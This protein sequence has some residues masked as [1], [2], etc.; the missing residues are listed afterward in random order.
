MKDALGHGSNAR[1]SHASKID[2]IGK[3]FRTA[4][5]AEFLAARNMSKR[6]EYF[7]PHTP[8]EIANFKLIMNHEGTVGAAVA[9]DGDIQSVFNNSG[10]KGAG[11][12]AIEIAK[13][14]GGQKLDAFDGALPDIY[15][16]HGFV[17]DHRE[18]N[19]NPGGPDVVYMRLKKPAS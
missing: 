14:L 3:G 19:Y 9:P 2:Q 5:P 13:K 11:G 1:G 10:V 15:K 18:K 7:T 17:E 16:K 6:T 12:R 4:S 8:E